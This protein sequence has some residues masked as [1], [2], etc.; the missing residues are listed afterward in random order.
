MIISG[1]RYVS[2]N[3]AFLLFKIKPENFKKTVRGCHVFVKGFNQKK[4]IHS[5]K[6]FTS[7]P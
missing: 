5:L 6:K 1:T 3:A 7:I 2:G 4:M